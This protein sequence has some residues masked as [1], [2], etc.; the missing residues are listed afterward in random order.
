MRLTYF[1]GDGNFGHADNFVL[2][3]TSGWTDEDWD[4]I[5]N[6]AAWE[7]PKVAIE[8]EARNNG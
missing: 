1:S 4:L 2:I 6:T 8:I 5:E 3:D 7:L